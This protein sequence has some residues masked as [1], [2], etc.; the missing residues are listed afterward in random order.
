MIV[1]FPGNRFNGEIVPALQDLVAQGTIRI[2]DL[3]F[4]TKDGEGNVTVAELEDVD[5][6]LVAAFAG[7]DGEI[8]NLLNEEDLELLAES[9]PNNNSAALLVWENA[10]AARFADAVRGARGE[11][12]ADGRIPHAVV[13]A[14]IDAVSEAVA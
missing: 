5:Y 6:D 7:L 12:L 10:W 8:G 3:V 14:A 9:I 13:Q 4:V 2:M 11:V 1:A